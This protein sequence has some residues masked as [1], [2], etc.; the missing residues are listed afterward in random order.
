M[1]LV[2][3]FIAYISIIHRNDTIRCYHDNTFNE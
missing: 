1:A 3:G 2:F